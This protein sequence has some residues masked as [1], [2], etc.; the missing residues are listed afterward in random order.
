MACTALFSR[1]SPPWSHTSVVGEG[2]LTL[3][4]CSV[5]SSTPALASSGVP[6]DVKR[7]FEDITAT[8]RGLATPIGSSGGSEVAEML[9][10][11]EFLDSCLV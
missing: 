6:E 3:N 2:A 11:L 1:S 7:S 8:E 9:L 10:L 4:I 5:E